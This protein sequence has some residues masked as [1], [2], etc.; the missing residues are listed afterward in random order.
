M[1]N[2]T[3]ADASAIAAVA[4]KAYSRWSREQLATERN[5]LIQIAAFPEGQFVAVKDDRII[6]YCSSLIV[7]LLDDSP[8]YAHGEITGFGSFSTHDPSGNILYGADIAVDPDYQGQGVSQKLYSARKALLKRHKLKQMIAGGRI[9]GY[10]EHRGKMS[11]EEYVAK[12]VRG[13]LRDKALNAHLRAGYEVRSVHF[14]YIEDEQ[15]L[16]YLNSPS[17]T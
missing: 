14:G 11:A 8:W 5:N 3:A 2:S 15:S 9:P 1:R 12:V 17:N 6:G 13:E 7:Y 10:I 16:G 4:S